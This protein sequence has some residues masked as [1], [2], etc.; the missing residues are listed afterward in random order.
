MTAASL[1]TLT[2]GQLL[3]QYAAILGELRGRGIVRTGNAP[4]GDYAEYLASLVY[5]G[6]LEPNSGKSY[7]LVAADGRRVQVKAITI[8][9][10]VRAS[11]T[12]SAFR[13][14]DFDVAAMLALD[15]VTYEIVWARE[16]SA[17]EVEEAA[18]FSAHINAHSVRSPVAARLG[19]DVT[20]L[21]RRAADR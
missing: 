3:A 6:P 1:D 20:D 13:S 15:R 17:A 21:F 7:D 11:A 8:A 16:I 2:P 14:F 9:D 12:F 18:R 5:N 19:I 4:L 10:G